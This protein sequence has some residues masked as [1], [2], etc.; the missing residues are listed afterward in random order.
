LLVVSHFKIF[1]SD[2]LLGNGNLNQKEQ[3]KGWGEN[4]SQTESREEGKQA[5]KSCHQ[6]YDDE[7]NF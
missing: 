2:S 1:N 6:G 5:S 4:D 7:F 3:H